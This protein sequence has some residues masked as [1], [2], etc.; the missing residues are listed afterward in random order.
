M[1]V[2]VDRDVYYMYFPVESDSTSEWEVEMTEDEYAFC[3]DALLHV[4]VM[5][6]LI[7]ARLA[8]A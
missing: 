5:D 7:E 2:K 1:R 6:E 4:R 3:M 8:R